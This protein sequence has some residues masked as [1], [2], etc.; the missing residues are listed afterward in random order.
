MSASFRSWTP[1]CRKGSLPLSLHRRPSPVR[2]IWTRWRGTPASSVIRSGCRAI[3]TRRCSSGHRP[4]TAQSPTARLP[5]SAMTGAVPMQKAATSGSPP[6]T[7]PSQR[8]LR[9]DVRSSTSQSSWWERNSLLIPRCLFRWKRPSED[10]T[11]ANAWDRRRYPACMPAI[12]RSALRFVTNP[13]TGSTARVMSERVR[14]SSRSSPTMRGGGI[15]PDI[16]SISTTAASVPLK[17]AAGWQG[18]GTPA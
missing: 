3:R 1:L 2:S 18:A 14:S 17:P 5:S 10:R 9:A 13:C 7:A 15:R 12:S 8:T 16:G 11:W 4:M 6:A